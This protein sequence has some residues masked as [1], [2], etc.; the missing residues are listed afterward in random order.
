MKDEQVEEVEAFAEY[1]DNGRGIRLALTIFDSEG[2][3]KLTLLIEQA[4]L[5]LISLQAAA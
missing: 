2:P 4:Q 3:F 1:V 5:T